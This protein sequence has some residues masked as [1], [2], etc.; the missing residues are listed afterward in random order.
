[1]ADVLRSPNRDSM[2]L[3]STAAEGSCACSRRSR[4][5]R[6]KA[7]VSHRSGTSSP[8]V[9]P[10]G[11]RPAFVLVLVLAGCSIDPNSNVSGRSMPLPPSPK[12]SARSEIERDL[13]LELKRVSQEPLDHERDPRV[14]VWLS[15]GSATR[16]YPV[17]LANDGSDMGWREP[18]AFF[19]VEL[20]RPSGAWEP[21]PPQGGMRCGVYDTDWAKDVVTLAP[22]MRVKMP[23]MPY[24]SG[25]LGDATRARVVAHYAYGDHAR[26]K[27]QILPQLHSIPAYSLTSAPLEIE[28]VHPYGLELRLKGPLPSASGAAL[29]PAVD[30]VVENRS[31]SPR[32]VGT[33]ETGAQLWLEVVST[34]SHAPHSLYTATAPTYASTERLPAGAKTTIVT[35]RTST[36]TGWILPASRVQRVRA[37]WRIW[38]RDGNEEPNQRRVESPWVEVR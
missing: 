24:P 17:V 27:S 11:M 30:V 19:R 13:K 31:S 6:A 8:I 20:L 14:E 15:N 38:D 5:V 16:G 33:P 37:I 3:D 7:K 29:G 36:D 21:A 26:D 28:I 25:E 18:H 4:G 9:L 2:E 34:D 12:E 23:W 22:G 32:P 1:M 10:R 35:A